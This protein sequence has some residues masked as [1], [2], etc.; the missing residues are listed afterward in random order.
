MSGYT[1]Q[2]WADNDLS[3]PPS[4]ARFAYIEDGVYRAHDQVVTVLPTAATPWFDGMHVRV[5]VPATAVGFEAWW[6]FTYDNTNGTTQPWAFAG[7]PSCGGDT[8]AGF[9]TASNVYVADSTNG[10]RVTVPFKGIYLVTYGAMMANSTVNAYST[11]SL[12]YGSAP[13]AGDEVRYVSPTAN[14]AAS[15]SRTH[16][17]VVANNNQLIEAQYGVSAGTGTFTY[18][19]MHVTPIRVG[20]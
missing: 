3:K 13:V 12:A 8:P 11:M 6:N 20:P 5:R 17:I 14:A 16:G 2:S 15:V 4:A 9:S 1:Q 18:R 10:P 7:G 19:F